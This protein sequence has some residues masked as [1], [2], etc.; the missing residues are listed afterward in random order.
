V[1]LG[2][3]A[4][5]GL[6]PKLA[7]AVFSAPEGG[8]TPP[9]QGS[10]GWVIVHVTKVTP[11]ESKTFDNVKDTLR[12][13]MIKAKAMS[14]AI[15]AANKFEDARGAGDTLSEAAAKVGLAAVHVP[16][17][18]QTGTS[19]DGSK[20][21]VPADPT[22]LERA[23]AQEAGDEGDLFDNADHS[24][25]YVIKVDGVTPPSVKPLDQVRAEVVKGWS[26][27]KRIELLAQRAKSLFEQ[28]QKENSLASV[29]KALSRPPVVAQSLKRDSKGDIFA[30]EMLDRL[31][32]IPPGAVTA[33]P[34]AKGEGFVIAR[35][36]QVQNRTPESDPDTFANIQ[37]GAAQQTAATVVQTLAASARE[38]EGA[39]INQAAFDRVFGNGSE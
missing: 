38:T 22:F 19:P 8:Y 9:T 17:V 1:K 35:V 16:A 21:N 28:A 26:E 5:S 2:S 18:D 3:F 15:D 25:S 6:D 31:F 33:G 13:Q 32:G 37:R 34:L 30:P 7:Q 11:G 24:A 36:T 4:K 27:Q 10:F 29:S 14:M 12:S 23:F 39:T 20:A